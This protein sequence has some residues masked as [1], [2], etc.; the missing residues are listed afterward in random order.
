MDIAAAISLLVIILSFFF[1]LVFLV[2]W[3]AY[4]IIGERYMLLFTIIIAF[5]S[6]LLFQY[7][8]MISSAK[9]MIRACLLKLFSITSFIVS[10]NII[11]E[12]VKGNF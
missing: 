6:V 9:L 7:T 8:L 3:L 10:I 1:S 4:K 5:I 2:F 11:I 12:H